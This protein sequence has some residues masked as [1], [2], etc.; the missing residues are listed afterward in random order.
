MI[1]SDY[2]KISLGMLTGIFELADELA[3]KLDSTV[4]VVVQKGIISECF[5]R[6]ELSKGARVYLYYPNGTSKEVFFPAY[7]GE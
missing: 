6:E 3:E 2:V 4:P 1:S 7:N 5:F